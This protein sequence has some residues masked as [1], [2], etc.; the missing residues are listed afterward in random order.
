VLSVRTDLD[1]AKN[2]SSP[3][4]STPSKTS[5]SPEQVRNARIA[6]S[7]NEQE[8]ANIGLTQ[9]ATLLAV[10]GSI[11]AHFPT[12]NSNR[13]DLDYLN[14]EAREIGL[15]V[16]LGLSVLA[17]IIWYV[18]NA[19][20]KKDES[21]E[22]AL[23]RYQT[24]KIQL[25]PW[26]RRFKTGVFFGNN[27]GLTFAE[28]IIQTYFFVLPNWLKWLI[29]AASS[30]V[31]G[32]IS[33]VLA[34]AFF[35]DDD[36]LGSIFR[37]GRDGWARYA[38]AGMQL[39][40]YIGA[41]A[42]LF[43]T[44]SG[45][46]T[47]GVLIGAAVGGVIGFI[48]MA[49]AVPLIN[50]IIQ[51][52]R[53]PQPPK[54]PSE[55]GGAR[56]R[57]LTHIYGLT[58]SLP[59]KPLQ[60]HQRQASDNAPMPHLYRVNYIRTGILAG[61][62]LG[63]VVAFAIAYFLAPLAIFSFVVGGAAI[64]A[65]VGAVG[66]GIAGH[67]ISKAISPIGD[68][69]YSSWDYGARTGFSGGN[70]NGLGILVYGILVALGIDKHVQ[71]LKDV[72]CNGFGLLMATIGAAHD[73]ISVKN[74][75]EITEE[76]FRKSKPLIPWSQR[77]GTFITLGGFAGSVIGY[78]IG[79]LIGGPLGGMAGA[80]IGTGVSALISGGIGAVWG[81]AIY[82]KYAAFSTFIAAKLR[83]A[84]KKIDDSFEPVPPKN[85]T[86]S[87]TT[88][89]KQNL[90]TRFNEAPD[91]E[92]ATEYPT[93]S[94]APSYTYLHKKKNRSEKTIHTDTKK[95]S[96]H[97]SQ[98]K[99]TFMSPQAKSPREKLIPHDQFALPMKAGIPVY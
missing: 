56:K 49:I 32:I 44:V 71:C 74:L 85:T 4:T 21:E 37:L 76:E 57:F 80:F 12:D 26:F 43:I 25:N 5:I 11:A 73:G 60:K 42:G 93:K 24:I 20:A 8:A 69:A 58:P 40:N 31:C 84:Q 77:V 67:Y 18:A 28:A 38:K 70:Q 87:T 68:R 50:F 64:G 27:I 63:T 89:V 96:S 48:A 66:L 30:A 29:R 9:A 99:L 17:A 19:F 6:L 10:G 98:K 52:I 15:G 88:K 47:A 55:G 1:P 53:G 23:K 39:G 22:Q 82:L 94:P 3:A 2:N 13:P 36:K 78:V 45:G 83:T 91:L 41:A 51:K 75:Q 34:I 90:L 14:L 92:A 81:E 97:F 86:L 65:T 62:A 46:L 7:I 59:S 16:G 33:G 72:L 35:A 54:T 79:T 95:Q 61:A